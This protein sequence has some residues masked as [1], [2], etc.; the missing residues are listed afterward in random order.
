VFYSKDT[1][2]KD[3]KDT[4]V[5]T[6]SSKAPATLAEPLLY[7]CFIYPFL[8]DV[9]FQTSLFAVVCQE[10]ARPAQTKEVSGPSDWLGDSLLQRAA[11]FG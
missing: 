2:N 6:S 4:K 1:K 8:E 11:K 10:S 3:T 7:T 5:S 9:W